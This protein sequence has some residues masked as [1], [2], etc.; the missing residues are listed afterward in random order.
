MAEVPTIFI[1]ADTKIKGAQ[2][3]NHETKQQ[4]L[5][6]TL[7]FLLRDITSLTRI[8]VILKL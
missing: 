8:Q 2:T 7:P 5:L 6:I 3:E 1:D 4:L